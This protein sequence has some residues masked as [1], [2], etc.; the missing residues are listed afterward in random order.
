M[1]RRILEDDIILY[2]FYVFI[3]IVERDREFLH[4]KAALCGFCDMIPVGGSVV[5]FLAR[6]Q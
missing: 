3:T 1:I 6:R 2:Q 4:Q 5:L